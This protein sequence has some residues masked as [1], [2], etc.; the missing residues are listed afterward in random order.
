MVAANWGVDSACVMRGTAYIKLDD[1]FG[2]VCIQRSA[3]IHSTQ[4]VSYH[5]QLT[6]SIMKGSDIILII[7]AILLPPVSVVRILPLGLE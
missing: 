5:L 3:S 2:L 1:F 6:T 4:D 7:V